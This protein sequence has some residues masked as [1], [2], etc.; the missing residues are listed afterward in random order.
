MFIC[1]VAT[2][3]TVGV[4]L[5]GWSIISDL[6]R[7]LNTAIGRGARNMEL[8]AGVQTGVQEL[9]AQARAVQVVLAVQHLERLRRSDLDKLQELSR[10]HGEELPPAEEASCSA[11]HST[12][13]LADRS[14]TLHKSAVELQRTIATLRSASDGESVALADSMDNSVSD[15]LSAYNDFQQ[16]G[17]TEYNAAHAISV[18]RMSPLA[19]KTFEL[20][21]RLGAN[22]KAY[23]ARLES[24]ASVSSAR[25]RTVSLVL[26]GFAV[27]ANALT[28]LVV[29]R[30][31]R[32]L[33][34]ITGAVRRESHE[35]TAAAAQFSDTSRSLA[36]AAEETSGCIESAAATGREVVKRALAAREH[37]GEGARRIGEVQ[38][39]VTGMHGALQH[40]SGA[41]GKITE[42][43]SRIR[44]IVKTIEEIA[45]QTNLLALNA[46]VEAAR[47]GEAGRGFAVLAGE[48]RTLATRCAEAAHSTADL[49]DESVC[50]AA[51]AVRALESVTTAA[52]AVGGETRGALDMSQRIRASGDE[53]V[54]GVEQIASLLKELEEAARR[55]ALTGEEE[56]AKSE[57]LSHR[58]TSLQEIVCDLAR[59]TGAEV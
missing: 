17:S 37:I 55:V 34:T 2:L 29:R 10:K 26:L 50:N 7:D 58:S 47:A 6:G 59:M 42:S 14:A 1:G 3:T 8:V 16:S 51:G 44:H 25:N 38:N 46:S 48:V 27:L 32:T 45:F 19:Q 15:W 9:K 22:Q 39:R 5:A 35:I 33:R 56:L 20:A 40:L 23:L 49:I 21:A 54:Q 18:E 28:L 13:S 53:Q 11:C 57:D 36:C 30:T 43:G 12:G 31:T 24:A 52:N 4:T 41:M